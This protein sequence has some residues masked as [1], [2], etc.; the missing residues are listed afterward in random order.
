[1]NTLKILSPD[2]ETSA[3]S[4]KQL[5]AA[6]DDES[7][8]LRGRVLAG[9]G[10]RLHESPLV[11]ERI[12]RA[13]KAPKN[14][15]TPFFGYIMVSWLGVMSVLENGTKE[16]IHLVNQLVK[17]WDITEQEDLQYHLKNSG[18]PLDLD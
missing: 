7:P 16:Q 12:I 5:L 2:E 4:T 17:E 10:E 11:F 8:Y 9:L 15:T 6:L 1:M 18:L 14:R 13:I 3:L